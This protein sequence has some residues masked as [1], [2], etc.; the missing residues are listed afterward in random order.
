M[1]LRLRIPIVPVGCN[2][3]ERL[4][5]GGSPFAKRGTVA[6]RIGK[7][8]HYE[9]LAPFHVTEDYAPFSAAAERDHA[10][11]FRGVADF[12]TRR[13]D[14]LLD[15]EYQLAPEDSAEVEARSSD[16]FV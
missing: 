9:E 11:A 6:Y 10:K 14:S 16:R 12:V 4:Y 2:G 1:A 7:P 15:P 3:S 5:P 13:I 8:I